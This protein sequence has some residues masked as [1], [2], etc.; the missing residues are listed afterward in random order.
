MAGRRDWTTNEL[1]ICLAYYS[2][3]DRSQRRSPPSWVLEEISGLINR[4]TGSVSLR[5]A[6]YTS[7]DPLFTRSGLKSMDGGGAHVRK[8]WN[9]CAKNDGELDSTKISRA[10]ARALSE[11]ISV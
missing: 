7:V 5:F 8:I 2:T 1:L 3:L 11:S 10:L 9:E 6:N 4:T